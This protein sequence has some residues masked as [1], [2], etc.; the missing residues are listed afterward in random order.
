GTCNHKTIK[1]DYPY[2]YSSYFAP[3]YRYKRLKELMALPGKKSVNDLWMY[4]R[5]KKN[6]MA[7]K[8]SPIMAKTLL[9]YDDTKI[10]GEFLSTWDFLDDPDKAA[11]AIFQTTYKLFALLVFE[12]DLGN[13]KAMIMLN[14]WYFWQEKLEK[15]VL[16][17]N[18]PWFDNIR[19][20]DITE[21]LED[22]FHLADLRAKAF[23]SPTL[24]DDPEK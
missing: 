18:S 13:E 21:S 9:K 14:N 23:L 1:N 11:P 20:K 3:S 5:D 16:N 17:G 8:I 12:D 19:T 22:L 7:E 15:M 6:L 2:Y 10:M 4:Q 24:G